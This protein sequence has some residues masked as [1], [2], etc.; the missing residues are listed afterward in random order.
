[1]A[2]VGARQGKP[3]EMINTG[4]AKRSRVRAFG[5]SFGLHLAELSMADQGDL[6]PG[7]N[8]IWPN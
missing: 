2:I 6:W 1:M 7:E 4:N 5:V 8:S 3:W